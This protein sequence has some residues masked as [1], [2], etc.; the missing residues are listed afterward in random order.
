MSESTEWLDTQTKMQLA[1]DPP[2]KLAPPTV[3][4]FSLVLLNRGP[5]R[6]R[7]EGVLRTLVDDPTSIV[8]KCPCIVRRGLSLADALLGQFELIC[9]DSIST[10]EQQQI[11]D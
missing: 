4:G 1:A 5:N 11:E 10:N 6:Q 2:D 8:T 3:G 7:V 9:A